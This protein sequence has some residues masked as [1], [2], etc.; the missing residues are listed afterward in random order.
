[1]CWC[2]AAFGRWSSGR[3]FYDLAALGEIAPW[4]GEDWFGVRSSGIFFPDDEG[5]GAGGALNISLPQRRPLSRSRICAPERATPLPPDLARQCARSGIRADAGRS[6]PERA[7][8]RGAH[9]RQGASGRGARRRS[10][11]GPDE[12]TV[13]LTQR[14]S[15]MRSHS[16]QIAFPGGKIDDG[17]TPL[18]A[19]LRE[20]QEE[21][22]LEARFIEPLGWLDPY[23]TGTGY[24]IMPLVA[25]RRSVLHPDDQP[26]ARSR[27]FSRRR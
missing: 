15:H 2:A 27:T 3:L 20:A 4:E 5:G 13:L 12:P 7:G 18:A 26:R 14:A 6:C 1:M 23:L 11:R 16:G 17:E 22:G 8:A 25:H 19:A 24:R 21:I 9:R 10:S